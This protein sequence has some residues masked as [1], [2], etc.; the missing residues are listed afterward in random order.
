MKQKNK[1]KER[2]QEKN[3]IERLQEKLKS[4]KQ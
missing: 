2:L 1:D 4:Q 3:N